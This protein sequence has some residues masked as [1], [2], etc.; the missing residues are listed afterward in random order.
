VYVYASADMV[1]NLKNYTRPLAVLH[2]GE[3]TISV[4]AEIGNPAV[5]DLVVRREPS[6]AIHFVRLGLGRNGRIAA[7]VLGSITAYA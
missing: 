5:L 7:A 4:N 2:H 6:G 3:T 1:G